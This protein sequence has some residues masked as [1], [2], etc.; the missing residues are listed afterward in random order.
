MER[1]R[2]W[3]H[4]VLRS[5]EPVLEELRRSEREARA[6]VKESGPANPVNPGSNSTIAEW[7][8]EAKDLADQ[9]LEYEHEN[10]SIGQDASEEAKSAARAT[11]QK[12]RQQ[13]G[14]QL[15]ALNELLPH[16][17]DREGL[18]EERLLEA[19]QREISPTGADE[20]H[21]ADSPEV[22]RLHEIQDLRRILTQWTRVVGL[23]EDFQELIGKS[24]RV[25]AA[26]CL[27]SG[28]LFPRSHDF[29]TA[30]SEGTFD[31]AIVDEAGRATVP[32]ILIPIVRS[33][34]T[35]LVGDE[36]QLPPMVDN[37]FVA[38]DSRADD[39]QELQTSLFQSL[40]EQSEDSVADKHIA[41]LRTQYRM[42]PHIGSLISEVFYDGS[43]E[44]G[45]RLKTR[46]RSIEWMPAPV[47]WLSTSSQQNRRESRSGQ[48][49]ENISETELALHLLLRLQEMTVRDRQRPSVGVI[50]G[51]SAQVE[52]LS[53]RIDS[54]NRERWSN[55]DID[56]ATVDSFQGREC[57]VIIYS[58]VRSNAAGQIGFL[59]DHRRLNVALSRAKE[60]LVVVGDHVMMENAT[61]G[62]AV[63]PFA[64][65]IDHMKSHPSECK[66]VSGEVQK[67]L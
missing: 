12:S 20:D 33:E 55:L 60:L 64:S 4:D 1:A 52:R 47:T 16:P 48:S 54:E 65:V 17:I 26:T 14:E 13:L 35:V 31:W 10:A 9:L 28:R 21:E 34:R 45:E 61:I 44:N 7:F 51:Y 2:S 38:N 50:S 24:A 23:T 53:A 56:I 62:S 5:C 37:M 66:I 11:V 19:I 59:R 27:F 29:D 8:A 67:W 15:D 32:E 6:T 58:S 57:N 43:L 42:H 49:F 36:R 40:I 46:R 3:R 63:N 39:R 18:T 30:T 22:T 25:L 41:V